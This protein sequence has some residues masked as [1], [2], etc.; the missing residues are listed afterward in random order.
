VFSTICDHRNGR[1]VHALCALLVALCVI[2]VMPAHAQEQTS[3]PR[4]EIVMVEFGA[5]KMVTEVYKPQGV[6]PFPVIVYAH[7]RAGDE[8]DRHKLASPIPRGHVR[9]WLKKGFAVVASL[10]PGYGET[11]GSD[12]ESSGARYDVFGN[13]RSRPDFETPATHAQEAMLA[14]VNWVRAQ[15]WA[16]RDF[17]ILEGTSMGGLAVVATAAVNPAGVVGYINFAGGAGGDPQRA[18]GRSCGVA[19]MAKLI[20]A[21]GHTTRVPGLWLYAQN[22]MYWG[23]D[24]PRTWHDAFAA[25]GGRAD[26]IVTA[27][28]PDTDGHQLLLRGGKLWSVHTDRFVRELTH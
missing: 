22:D 25:A 20:T 10:R 26:F 18:P 7:G 14:T 6:E 21:F 12:R 11:G 23:A 15:P 17:I 24:A 19:D 27:P 16:R 4:P 9:Y 3:R 1:P 2:A 8:V 28:V 5:K 13:C